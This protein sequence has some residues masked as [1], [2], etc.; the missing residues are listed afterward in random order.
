MN[1]IKSR[2]L[3]SH[4]YNEEVARAI[5]TAIVNEFFPEFEELLKTLDKI[6]NEEPS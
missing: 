6:K 1:M 2:N 5:S 4:T 3:T